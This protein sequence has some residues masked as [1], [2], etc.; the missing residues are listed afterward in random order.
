MPERC[1][2]VWRFS[3]LCLRRLAWL[4]AIVLTLL[5][6][7]Y[8]GIRH[9]ALPAVPGYRAEVAE[10]LAGSLGLPVE[11]RS[12]EADWRGLHPRL[13]LQGLT[14]RDRYGK[15]ALVLERVEA[16]VAWR[17]ILVMGLRLHRLL[18]DA[19]ELTLRRDGAGRLFVAGLAVASGEEES[20]FAAWLLEQ[21][22]IRVRQA[23]LEWNDELR[24]APPLVLDKVD[25]R[26]E[27]R[28]RQ[29]RFGLLAVPPA[30]LA[31][32]LEVRGVL[33][34]QHLG[35]L[36]EW[37]GELYAGLEYASLGAWRP[38]VDY[39]FEL[40]GAGG[41][42]AW[43][44]LSEGRLVG[45]SADFSLR[46][47]RTRLGP[48]LEEIS[49]QLA[50][51]RLRFRNERGVQ[52]LSGQGVAVHTLDGLRVT[53]TDF[54]LRLQEKRGAALA[55]GEFVANQLDLGVLAQLAERLPLDAGVRKRLADLAPTGSVAPLNL[56]WSGPAGGLASYSM[57]ARFVNLGIQ[58][59]GA[60]PGFAGLSGTVEGNDRGG[61]FSLKGRDAR[62]DLPA[63]FAE[64]RLG[65]AE[66]AV[67][68]DW[69]HPD[70]QTEV[71]LKSV[72]FANRDARGTAS[73]RYR[74]ATDALGEID[75]QARLAEADSRAVWRYLPSVVS[76]SARDWLQHSLAGGTAVDTRLVL[77]G[78]LEKFPFRNPRDG[79]FRVTSRIREGV[80]D[81]AKGWPR[82]EGIAGELVFEGPGMT[83]KA[84]RGRIFGVELKNVTAVLPDFEKEEVVSIRG[85]AA[86]ATQDFLRYIAE[87]PVSAMINHFTAPFRAEGNGQLQLQLVLPLAGLEHSRVKGDY[88][89][90]RNQLRPDPALPLLAEA[91]GEVS[92]T[93]R[94]LSVR[95][96]SARVFGDLATVAGG[97]RPDGSVLLQV[98][99]S[100]AMPALRRAL[101]LP[102]LDNLAGS[103]AWKGSITV[104]RQGG[105]GFALESHLL[106]VASALP[107]PFRKSASTP[108]PL[109]F[110]IQVPPAVPG[111]AP[112]DV[113]RLSVGSTFQ[114]QFQ[115]Q[116]EGG[117]M[118]VTR[119]GMALHEPL[120]LADKGVMLAVTAEQLDA[121]AW[122]KALAGNADSR[123]GAATGKGSDFPLSGI[124]LKATELRAYG[125]RFGNVNLRAVMEEGGWQARL[126]S[127]EATGDILWRDQGRGRLQARFRQL[128]LGSAEDD[129]SSGR[130]DEER[131]SQLPG[132]DVTADSFILRG[133][134][135]GRLELKAANRGDAWRLDQLNIVNPD[136]VLSG[137]GLWRPGAREETR[138]D[139]RLDVASVEKLLGR[140]GYPEAVR[141]GKGVLEGEVN[142]KGPPTAL[143]YPT[144][145]G[146][147]KLNV[148]GGQFTQL[149]P[150][151]GRLLGVLSLQAL[152]RRITLDFRDVFSQGFAFDRI[153]GSIQMN[154]GV[155]RTEDLEIFGPAARVF[156]SGHA[157]AARETQNLRV[158][159]QPT[160]SES[161]A[162]GSAIATTGAINPALGLAAYLVQ[163]ALRDPVEKLFSFEYAVTGAWADPKVEKLSARPAPSNP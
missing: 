19:P 13:Q 112:G 3:G 78:N 152:P 76:K 55:R 22:E 42:K 110:E 109:R 28:G 68:G 158:R 36:D 136:G 89:F 57:D 69:S 63:I 32:T 100:T 87:S 118:V 111:V 107:E 50:S 2:S 134:Q 125:Q 133:R 70:G 6:V 20:G 67:E 40:E 142:W 27:N 97:T 1:F 44:D 16:E 61:R 132:L 37:R 124:A 12:L 77:K 105:V 146:R 60:W 128:S 65:L 81:Y 45:A 80:L 91:M 94:Q 56:K 154:G 141:R 121:D 155:L 157:D 144:L 29:H 59:L 122:R 25:F 126:S 115:R 117:R 129:S 26:L 95:N 7:A 147:M 35:R 43:L 9:V 21:R 150:G 90:T 98:Q 101:E 33:N 48:Q 88:Q 49:M 83:L 123:E 131:L 153:S 31:A 113:L 15:A 145:G 17:S 130:P 24:E 4:A 104:P 138:L 162:V 99:G 163:K 116:R 159:V 151:A 148:E 54:Y 39:P 73:G 23:R 62:L 156:M 51:G 71:T 8:L 103:A 161:V 38:W 160:L 74:A 102:L 140:L 47:A 106:G 46:D 149:D 137:E 84:Q 18:I 92:F 64:P 93:E 85:S 72:S 41:L 86:G 96:A 75:L 114:A 108:L 30:T 11:I 66:V 82:I 58:P 14:V 5:G 53:P 120:R 139:F 34:G 10:L 119:G 143:H 127:R 52:E 79:T 135:L